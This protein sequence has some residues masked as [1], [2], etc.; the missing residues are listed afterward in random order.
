[1]SDL[2]SVACTVPWPIEVEPRQRRPYVLV[3]D[4]TGEAHRRARLEWNQRCD[5]IVPEQR[6]WRPSDK[7][8]CPQTHAS[9]PC[10]QL[11][12]IGNDNASSAT[13]AVLVAVGNNF[14]SANA[15]VMYEA[16]NVVTAA[17]ITTGEQAA[18]LAALRDGVKPEWYENWY[19]G[20]GYCMLNLSTLLNRELMRSPRYME[21]PWSTANRGEGP[22][23]RRHTCKA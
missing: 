7:G 21:W 20:L 3:S 5:D 4:A 22:Q 6:D 17:K 1:M 18:E 14:E 10:A 9:T 19:D 16:R 23:R 13:A 2:G 8:K 12:K 11:S 15:A